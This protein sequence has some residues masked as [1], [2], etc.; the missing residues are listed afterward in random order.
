VRA[1]G[2]R[3]NQLRGQLPTGAL[4]DADITALRELSDR[5]RRAG[6]DPMA[7]E[8]QRMVALVSQLELAALRAERATDGVPGTRAVDRVDDA[9][10]YR[11]N[12]AEYYRRLGGANDR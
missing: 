6:G 9:G 10:Q 2:E 7:A 3:L 8:Y 4:N 12:V 1:S 11:E 5:L